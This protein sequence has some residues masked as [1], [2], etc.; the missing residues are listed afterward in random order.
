MEAVAAEQNVYVLWPRGTSRGM[1]TQ[2]L[3]PLN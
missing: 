3:Q 2:G 1:L